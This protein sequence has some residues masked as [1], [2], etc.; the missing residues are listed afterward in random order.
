MG[1]GGSCW[2]CC[3]LLGMVVATQREWQR[4][5]NGS[6][7]ENGGNREGRNVRRGNGMGRS[8]AWGGRHILCCWYH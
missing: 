3:W 8:E 6:A 5:E 4:R 1:E 2:K 7:G